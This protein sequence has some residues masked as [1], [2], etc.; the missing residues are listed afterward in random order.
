MLNGI[1]EH[2]LIR[3]KVKVTGGYFYGGVATFYIST[4]DENYVT[5]QNGHITMTETEFHNNFRLANIQENKPNT[6][7]FRSTSKNINQDIIKLIESG[8][9]FKSFSGKTFDGRELHVDSG[10]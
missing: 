1:Y 3:D 10:S 8:Y 7:K 5:Q 6:N 9:E 4:L 2:K